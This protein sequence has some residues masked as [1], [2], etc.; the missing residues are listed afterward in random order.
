[1]AQVELFWDMA[2]A[3]EPITGRVASTIQ[4]HFSDTERQTACDFTEEAASFVPHM[5]AITRI[6]GVVGSADLI[7]LRSSC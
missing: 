5:H 2:L 4:P 3:N 7:A 6:S 1:M